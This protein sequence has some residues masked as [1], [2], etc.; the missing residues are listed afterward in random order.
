MPAAVAKHARH[1]LEAQKQQVSQP[2]SQV[3]L[4]TNL[5][6]TDSVAFGEVETWARALNPDEFSPREA[7][8]PLY[9]LKKLSDQ[10]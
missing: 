2:L 1:T 8:Q 6:A 4:F 3:D 7:L 10:V 9:Q 5:P